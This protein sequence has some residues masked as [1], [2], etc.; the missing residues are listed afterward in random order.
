MYCKEAAH[1][2]VDVEVPPEQKSF[3]VNKFRIECCILSSLDHRNVV[4]FVGVHFGRDK[5]DISLVMER[6]HT[7]LAKFVEKN[8][9]ITFLKRIS[10]LCDVSK[11][12]HY[13]HGLTP[14]LIHRDLTAMNVLLTKEHMAKIGD[15]G[16]SRFVDP[17]M[18]KLT[19][20]PGHFKY[21]PPECRV[22]NP[23]YTT[24]LDIFSFGNLILHTIN[25]ELPHVFD[26]EI[27]P[28][29]QI[30]LKAEGRVELMRRNASMMS[31][32][33]SLYPLVFRC[34]RDRP[35]GRPAAEEVSTTLREL[36]DRYPKEVCVCACVC[37]CA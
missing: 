36:Y 2:S 27:S 21:M 11:G 20:H 17:S 26:L 8:P 28:E 10:I 3:I 16:V 18:L 30:Q 4:S 15:L 7:D 33:H 29:E 34:L 31:E 12:L 22:V 5:D 35:E 9:N 14:P 6:L 19:E 25:G 37:M 23:R 13:L 1:N 32:K 24:K